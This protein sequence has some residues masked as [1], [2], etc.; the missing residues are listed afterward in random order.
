MRRVSISSTNSR[1]ESL[2]ARSGL[3]ARRILTALLL[4]A[5]APAAIS[6]D[7]RPAAA[8]LA[9]WLDRLDADGLL[10]AASAKRALDYEFCIPANPEAASEVIAIDPSAR[11]MRGS[12]GRVG[13][14]PG[15]WL[16]LGSTHQPA[17][18]EIIR[19]LAALP[20]VERIEP[21]FHE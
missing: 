10:G 6:A 4:V 1:T 16:V 8:G 20:Y 5:I 18:A 9:P 2:A 11:L 19:R 3:G 17:F 7:V 12:R 14:R 15:Q 13:C 21:A